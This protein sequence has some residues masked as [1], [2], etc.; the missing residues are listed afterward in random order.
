MT[1]TMNLQ[2]TD[3]YTLLRASLSLFKKQPTELQE[4][5][6]AQ[7][8]QQA[9]N[10]YSIETRILKTPEAGSVIISEEELH[11]AYQ[12]IRNRYVDEESFLI[13]LEKNNLTEVSL[14]SGLFRQCKIDVV[15]EMVAAR[16]PT[17]S[18]VEIGI[19]YHLHKE[20]FHRPELRD[21]S[22][23]FISINPDYPENTYENALSRSQELYTKLQKKPYKFADLALKHSEC[24]TALQ[25]GTLGTVP[26]GKLY[27][28]ID[29][30][31]FKLKEEEISQPVQS[32]IGFHLVLCQKIQRAETLSLQKAIPK[33]RQMMS[34]RARQ[35]CQRAWLSSLPK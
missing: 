28:E 4:Q 13:D 16:S 1:A 31:L 10:E 24:P 12:E 25:G 26:K 33:I 27:P 23:I 6:L 7:A 34:D 20:Q 19:Y 8:K 35:K 18:E 22:H 3:S 14:R 15:L 9:A 5:E 17:I 11:K 30:V 2:P 21:V 32:E 29:A